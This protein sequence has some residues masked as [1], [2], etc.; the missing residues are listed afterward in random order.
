MCVCVC[1]C[2]DSSTGVRVCRQRDRQTDRQTGREGRRDGGTE[3]EKLRIS[4]PV[5]GAGLGV[6]AA[7]AAAL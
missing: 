4:V 7:A 1:V 2:A 6:R 5:W 3:E